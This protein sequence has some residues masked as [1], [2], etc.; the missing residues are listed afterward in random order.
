MKTS[1]PESVVTS[2]PAVSLQ[3]EP[4]VAQHVLNAAPVI[5]LLLD[6]QGI[7]QH[8]NPFFEQLTGWRLD[9]IKGKDWFATFIPTRDLDRIRSLFQTALRDSPTRGNINP[10]VTRNGEEREI[11]WNDQVMRGADGQISCILAIGM[12][13]TERIRAERREAVRPNQLKNLSQLSLLL[14]GS[15]ELVFEQIVRLIGEQFQVRVAC[16]A[17]IEKDEL[18]FRAM[19][20]NGEVWAEAGSCLLKMTPC[21][22]VQ[23]T[24]D[25]R[26]YDRVTERFPEASFLRTHNAY[27]YCGFP[28][29]DKAGNVT[30]VIFV[31]DDKPRDFTEEEQHLLRIIGQRVATE[32]EHARVADEQQRAVDALRE[33]KERYRLL[34]EHAPYCIHGLNKQGQFVSINQAGVRMINETDESRVIGRNYLS[35]VSDSDRPRIAALLEAAQMGQHSEFEFIGG[36]G[37]VYRS[38]FVPL[39]DGTIMGISLDITEG[40]RAENI[41][42]ETVASLNEAQRI[43]S[44]GSWDFDIRNSRLTWSAEIYRIFEIDSKSFEASYETFLNAVYP[45]DREMVNAAYTQSLKTR[46]PYDIVHRLQMADGRIKFVRERW[47]TFYDQD[48]RPLRSLGTVQDVTQLQEAEDKLRASEIR[49]RMLVEQATDGIFL[50]RADGSVLDV[51]RQACESLGFSRDELIGMKVAEFAPFITPEELQE[52]QLQVEHGQAVT[53]ESYHRRKDGSKFPVEVRINPFHIANQPVALSV[54]RDITERKQADVQLQ[55]LRDVLAHMNRLGTL[56]EIASGLAHELNQPLGAINID[57]ST[58]LFLCKEIDSPK[59]QSCLQRISDQALRAGEIV[60]RMR[61]FIRRDS[62][63]K[64]PHEINRLVREVLMLLDDRLRHNSV[65]LELSL[66]ESLP[67]IAVDG[68]QIQQVLVNLVRNADDAMAENGDTPRVLTIRTEAAT[69]AIRIEI[70]D[71]GCGLD[72]EIAAKL[73]FP[74][75]TTKPSGLGLG[76][77]ICH[78]IVD[79][80]D[81][82]LEARSNSVRGTT[83]T[84][85]LPVIS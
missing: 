17:Q 61:S 19:Y 84:L 9:E 7:I 77:V 11:K 62:F 25:L 51:N 68:I 33:S 26:I 85:T 46:Q 1:G 10:I 75:Q 37:R 58:S 55:E 56:G 43:A 52:I 28:C 73:F 64:E 54:V 35:F 38:N 76:L 12:D 20:E 59:L 47:E 31:L 83:F 50:H 69:S 34:I 27:A 36:N 4:N 23:E 29:L 24:K 6:P 63:N 72:P 3:G 21:A 8:V 2:A 41:V 70:A 13:V 78:T 71:T 39:A 65:T 18:R 16:L 42:R 60:R 15:S 44:I 82:C 49:Y 32:I 5:V 45:E 22:T 14:A 48:E 40:K 79:A 81:G 53:F 67:A 57:A 30:A 66:A 80:H 74:F